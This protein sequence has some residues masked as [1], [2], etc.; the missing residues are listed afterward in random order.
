MAQIAASKGLTAEQFTAL[1]TD[2]RTQAID[3]AVKDGK[4]TQAQADWMKQ[5]GAAAYGGMMGAGRG[6]GMG[7]NGAGNP[8]ACPFFSQA[9]Q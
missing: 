6:R 7:W 2:A 9:N 1:M 3:Q 8:A 5:R 4:L